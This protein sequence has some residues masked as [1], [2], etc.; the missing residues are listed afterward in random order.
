MEIFGG[1]DWSRTNS[2]GFSDHR[3][4]RLRHLSMLEER[5]G[6]EPTITGLQPIAL[7]LGYLS[8]RKTPQDNL[9]G[10]FVKGGNNY[11]KLTMLVSK[12]KYSH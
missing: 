9:N 6:F 12:T 10:V 5:V 4:H 8:K 3:A 7:P 11:V 1:Q 2:Y